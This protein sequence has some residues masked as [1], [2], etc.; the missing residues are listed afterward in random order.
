MKSSENVEQLENFSY[1]YSKTLKIL[2]VCFTEL[3]LDELKTCIECI[4]LFENLRQLEIE[5]YETNNMVNITQIEFSLSLIG[6]KCTKLLKLDLYLYSVPITD[7]FFDIISN[8]K[9]IKRL[10]IVLKSNT[11]VK[12]S[13][14]SWRHCKQLYDMNIQYPELREDFFTNITTTLPRLQNFQIM[15]QLKFSPSF[16]HSFVKM[17]D[18]QKVRIENPNANYSII[19]S[20]T[21]YFKNFTYFDQNRDIDAIQVSAD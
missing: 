1:K 3:T 17:K 4:P 6:Q 8:F 2:R 7:R 15:T 19:N 13:V 10:L 5:I 9:V 12:G 21:R 18:I 16:I 20:D 14:E 11:V